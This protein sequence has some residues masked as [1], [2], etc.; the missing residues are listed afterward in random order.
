MKSG[1]AKVKFS[2]SVND[3][4]RS[5]TILKESRVLSENVNVLII[6]GVLES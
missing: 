3:T 4:G 2:G 1:G 6:L 5:D